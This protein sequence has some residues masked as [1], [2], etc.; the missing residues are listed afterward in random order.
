MVE[1]FIDIIAPFYPASYTFDG[2]T[3]YTMD[4]P[5][6]PAIPRV[7][8]AL[9]V[10]GTNGTPGNTKAVQATWTWKTTL[11]GIFKVVNLDMGNNN[12]FERV[13]LSGLGA[14]GLALVAE[15][16]SD[17]NGWAGRDGGQPTFFLQVS[18]TMNEKLRRAYRMT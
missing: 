6:S 11:G 15:V 12:S 14:A 10:V 17:G 9:A 8:T 18:Y 1:N 16:Q 13:T 5:T 4:T 2:Y 3:I 7:Q